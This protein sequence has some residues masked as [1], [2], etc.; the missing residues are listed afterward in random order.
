[1]KSKDIV[2]VGVLLGIGAIVRYIS[3]VVPGA[4]TS[5]LVIAFHALAIAL[6]L[7]KFTE[8]SASAWSQASSAR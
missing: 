7:P 8:A 4:I 1:M 2:I 6:I 3:L 5:N